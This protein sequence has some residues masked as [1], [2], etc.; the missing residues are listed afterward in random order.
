MRRERVFTQPRCNAAARPAA[1]NSCK[2]S[3]S[4]HSPR[5]N[6]RGTFAGLAREEL[7]KTEQRDMEQG[8]PY[9]P[10]GRGFESCQPRQKSITWRAKPSASRNCGTAVEPRVPRRFFV[11]AVRHPQQRAGLLPAQQ[12]VRLAHQAAD[13]GACVVSDHRLRGMAEQCCP[14]LR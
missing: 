9:E 8:S 1:A 10:R 7:I 11:S 4:S 6:S 3:V 5:A 2:G 12:A 14:V 13:I